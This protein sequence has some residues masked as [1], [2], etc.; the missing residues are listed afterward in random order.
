MSRIAFSKL[1]IIV[2]LAA[3]HSAN[4]QSNA[5][6]DFW[7]SFMEH[8]DTGDNRMVVMITATKN[9]T[10]TVSIPLNNFSQ[11]FSVQANDVV[12][13]TMPRMAETIGSERIS[14][15]AIHVNSQSPV[16]VYMHQ[17]HGYRSEATV[18]LPVSS[19][20][21]EYYVMSYT[22]IDAFFGSGTSEFIIVGIEDETTIN[23][24]VTDNTVNGL[25]KGDSRTITLNRGQT[26]QIKAPSSRDDL[27]GSF[28]SGDK[29]FNVFGGSS[30]SGVPMNCGTYDNLLEQM[31]PIDTWGSRYVTIPTQANTYDVFRMLS[32]SDNN[33]ITIT[34]LNGT[35]Q[36]YTLD[37]GEFVEY[38]RNTPTFIEASS[39]V[40][41]A[42]YLT[43]R[44]CTSN[45][46]GD[47]SMVILNSVEQ[48]R[49]TITMYNSRFQDIRQNYISIIGRTDDIDRVTFDGNFITDSWTAIGLNGE[50]SFVTLS[51]GVGSHTIIS[52]GCGVIASAFGLGDA[53][54]YAY[55]GGA[56]FNRINA[57]PIPDGECVGVPI[58]F[59]SGLPSGR[60]NVN[61]DVGHN[62]FSSEEHEFEYMYPDEEADYQVRITIE[63]LCFNETSMQDKEVKITFKQ[64]IAVATHIP[65]ICEGETLQLEVYDLANASY[66][67]KG[68]MDFQSDDQISIIENIVP[69][70][71]GEYKVIGI[72]F[73]C[74][75]PEKNITVDIKSTPQPS[76]GQDSVICERFGIPTIITPG[77]WNSYVW[78]DGTR[79]PSLSIL[80]G[81]D[82]NVIVTDEFNCIG[83]DSISFQPRCPTTFYIPTAFSPN[84][85]SVNDEFRVEGFDVLSMEMVILDKW[86]SAVF[87]SNDHENDWDGSFNGMSV[88]NGTYAWALQFRGYDAEG[89]EIEETMTGTVQVMR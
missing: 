77:N 17:Y 28:I 26:Y 15:N 51:V 11:S 5:G 31:N 39:P 82:Y 4:A 44:Q 69:E 49:D 83:M 35:V 63:D 37:E 47:P 89:F 22:G 84:G 76:L 25:V 20:S 86:G 55:A 65:A 66:V 57:N 59:Q 3:Y 46:E 8:I 9:T 16:S 88:S 56:S 10:G 71:S 1:L 50:F 27:T 62:G 79:A 19:L 85:D 52:E 38:Q 64:D 68:P 73:G 30:W 43:G 72:V 21:T 33:D 87:Q 78:S 53:E 58:Q 42:Q 23:Y 75:T 54:S 14:N 48:I 80:E 32:A 67:W 41:V 6:T 70:M 36:T 2:A 34:N 45:S 24:T 29:V 13:I 60:Y 7:L 40:L 61:W 12:L 81:G 18:V 74:K